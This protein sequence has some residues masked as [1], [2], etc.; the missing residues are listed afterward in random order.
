MNPVPQ[1]LLDLNIWHGQIT[2]AP[3]IG[4]LSNE[5]YIVNDDSGKYVVRFCH[6]IPVHHVERDHEAMVSKAAFEAGCAPEPVLYQPGAMVFRFIESR[7]YSEED[8][9][10]N[11]ERLVTLIKGFH[12]DVGRKVR[13]AGRIFWVFHVLRDYAATLKE[14]RSRFEGRLDEFMAV[15]NA[16]EDMQTPLPIVYTH[17]DLLPANFLDDGNRIWMIDFEYAGFSTA[18]FDLANL[19]A[20]AHFSSD[21]DEHLLQLYFGAPPTPELR[22]AHSAMK[23]A[24]ALRETMWAMVSEL[25]LNAPGVD[26]AAYANETLEHYESGLAAF[27]TSYGKINQ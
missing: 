9:R 26:Y 21:E 23:C 15:N 1:K 3:L 25:H 4:G 2:A 11:L 10:P 27:Q 6:D 7:T 14:G 13:G 5:S 12:R 24:S 17:N 20:N 19:A 18:M 16:M 8:I 22:K